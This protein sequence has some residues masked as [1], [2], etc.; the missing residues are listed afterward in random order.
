[1]YTSSGNSGIHT[2][3]LARLTFVPYLTIIEALDE[4][5]NSEPSTYTELQDDETYKIK[6]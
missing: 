3:N 1:M 4:P 5:R 6:K 2:I